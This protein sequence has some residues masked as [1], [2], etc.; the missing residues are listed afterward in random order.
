M[1]QTHFSPTFTHWSPFSPLEAAG[2]PGE[3]PSLGVGGPAVS[4]ALARL[5]CVTLDKLLAIL[6]ISFSL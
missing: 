3:N 1:S 2:S 6:S 4:L 5:S